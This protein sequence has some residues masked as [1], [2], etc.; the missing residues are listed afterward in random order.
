[1]TDDHCY[2]LTKVPTDQ[3]SRAIVEGGDVDQAE[4]LIPKSLTQFFAE[5]LAAGKTPPCWLA[6]ALREQLDR[7]RVDIQYSEP[8]RFAANLTPRTLA[9]LRP[10][11]K[12]LVRSAEWVRRS[13]SGETTS[14]KSKASQAEKLLTSFKALRRL[15]FAETGRDRGR[16]EVAASN[17]ALEKIAR[18]GDGVLLRS[19][20]EGMPLGI[21]IVLPCDDDQF[22]ACLNALDERVRGGSVSDLKSALARKD[23]FVACLSSIRDLA[24]YRIA[25]LDRKP[26]HRGRPKK[27]PV[28]SSANAAERRALCWSPQLRCAVIVETARRMWPEFLSSENKLC[29]WLWRE[30]YGTPHN[31]SAGTSRKKDA[32]FFDV[33]RRDWCPIAPLAYRELR[34]DVEGSFLHA[35]GTALR[36]APDPERDN[37]EV[38][39]PAWVLEAKAEMLAWIRATTSGTLEELAPLFQ[40]SPT[41]AERLLQELVAERQITRI[42]ADCSRFVVIGVPAG[43]D[44]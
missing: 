10:K 16:R 37:E 28:V 3:G 8:E 31:K 34:R 32:D 15:V 19:L 36:I 39:H 17:A 4:R 44:C 20:F 21:P 35:G 11:L 42:A 38:R 13:I 43:C 6:T 27:K 29:E 33:W 40:L 26:G 1:V 5:E 25:A 24:N 30:A 12:E 23:E 22:V 14:R 9:D 2:Q 7:L 41:L 18:N